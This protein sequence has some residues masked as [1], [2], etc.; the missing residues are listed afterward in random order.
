MKR[1]VLCWLALAIG[2]AV[3][4]DAQ[5][6][7]A[8]E[9]AMH[10]Q[11]APDELEWAPGPPV[12]PPGVKLAVLMGDPGKEGFFRLRAWMPAGYR[13]MPHW[14][15]TTES[16]TV[17]QGAVFLGMG[18]TF[19]KTAAS[20]IPTH[21]FAALPPL[22]PHWVY[23]EEETVIDLAAYGPFQVVYVNPEDDPS[24]QPIET[25]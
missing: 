1:Q 23:T 7:A 5:A 2:V 22:S 3:V 12:L 11:V 8:D 14:H 15:P 6:G 10:H 20:V 18:D 25:P 21:G 13:I 17:L 19:D 9:P 16:F 4:V 24:K